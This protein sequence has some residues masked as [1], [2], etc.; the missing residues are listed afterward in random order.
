MLDNAAI[1]KTKRIF[2]IKS[3]NEDIEATYH[4]VYE[5]EADNVIISYLLEDI[6]EDIVILNE[7]K[8]IPSFDKML[9]LMMPVEERKTIKVSL[10]LY[11]NQYPRCNNIFS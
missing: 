5:T 9:N 8:F 1:N 6:G 7:E 3:S 10:T 2:L 4:N 11:L